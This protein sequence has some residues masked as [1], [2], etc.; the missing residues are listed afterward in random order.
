VISLPSESD[1]ESSDGGEYIPGEH[2][3]DFGDMDEDGFDESEGF[4]S[5][6]NTG[7]EWQ[8]DDDQDMDADLED[9]SEWDAA[10]TDNESSLCDLDM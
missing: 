7:D 5:D 10:T 3:D 6:W 8:A 9:G 1:E 4:S 2:D